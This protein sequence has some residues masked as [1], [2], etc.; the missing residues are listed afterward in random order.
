[1]L[2]LVSE[3]LGLVT[4]GVGQADQGFQVSCTERDR[5]TQL[6]VIGRTVVVSLQPCREIIVIEVIGRALGLEGHDPTQC[7]CTVQR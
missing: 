5:Q 3:I 7:V 4:T 2:A 1:M 6:G